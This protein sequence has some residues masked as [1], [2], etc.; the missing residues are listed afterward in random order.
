[1]LIQ[2]QLLIVSG[3]I[4]IKVVLLLEIFV[5]KIARM[6]TGPFNYDTCKAFNPLC[7]VK[8][9]GSACVG[10]LPTCADVVAPYLSHC[11]NSVAGVCYNKEGICTP[12]TTYVAVE[13]VIQSLELILLHHI[14]KK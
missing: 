4:K 8:I 2:Q 9:D 12:S 13:V 11:T 3:H 10:I 7:T 5:S 1:M 14:V 6:Q